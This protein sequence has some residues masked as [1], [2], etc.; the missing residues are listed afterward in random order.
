M[1]YVHSKLLIADDATCVVGSCNTD[2]RSLRGGRDTEVAVVVDGP[3]VKE[4][5]VKLWRAHLGI[6]TRRPHLSCGRPLDVTD[7]TKCFDQVVE[8][9]KMNATLV[10]AC[11][12]LR[13]STTSLREDAR[14]AVGLGCASRRLAN[15]EGEAREK[16]IRRLRTARG[17]PRRPL[18]LPRA[19]SQFA[20]LAAWTLV[21]GRSVSA[22]LY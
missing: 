4:L 19:V 6:E 9:A 8:A 16:V 15:L 2:D 14:S 10:E 11:F 17:R 21:V 7:V 12:D 20:D 13:P 22:R 1:V 3:Q 5:R 18:R